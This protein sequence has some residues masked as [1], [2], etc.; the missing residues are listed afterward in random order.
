MEMVGDNVRPTG[1]GTAPTQFLKRLSYGSEDKRMVV[2]DV[3]QR[4]VMDIAQ[5]AVPPFKRSGFG[6]GNEVLE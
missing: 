3:V 1:R 5:R 4:V 2:Q 6:L